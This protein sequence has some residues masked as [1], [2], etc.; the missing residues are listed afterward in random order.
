MSDRLQAI[1]ARLDALDAANPESCWEFVMTAAGDVE[2]LLNELEE[3]RY[4]L[5][6][7]AMDAASEVAVSRDDYDWHLAQRGVTPEDAEAARERR[8]GRAQDA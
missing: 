2:W 6:C 4:R 1:R 5:A 8:F 7:A 3:V